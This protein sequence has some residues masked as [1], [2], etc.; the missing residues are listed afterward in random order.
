MSEILFV[1]TGNTCRSPMAAAL[2]AAIFEREGLKI[3]VSSAGVFA[4][5]GSDASKNAVLAMEHEKIDIRTHKSRMAAVEI[6]ENAAL[7]LAMTRSHLSHIKTVCP[8]ANAFT[9]GE[10]AGGCIDVSDPF[11]GNLDQYKNCAAQIKQL[12]EVCVAK[13]TEILQNREE[14]LT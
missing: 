1:C 6:L 13:F 2:A 7:V 5:D 9:L 4:S 3:T 11:G 8:A 14:D 10:Y 12:L